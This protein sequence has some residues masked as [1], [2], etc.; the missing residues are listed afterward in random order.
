VLLRYRATGEDPLMLPS[1]KQA[2]EASKMLGSRSVKSKP[3]TLV[4]T[5][6]YSLKKPATE[7]VI[8]LV[9]A[10]IAA[11]G[12]FVQPFDGKCETCGGSVGHGMVLMNDVPTY[13]CGT[14]QQHMI[15]QRR[16]EAEAYAARDVQFVKGFLAA[17]VAAGVMA[18]AVAWFYIWIDKD[19]MLPI[20]AMLLF[21]AFVGLPAGWVFG[22]T[23]GRISFRAQAVPLFLLGT[24]GGFAAFTGYVAMY[25]ARV[26]GLHVGVPLLKEVAASV[27]K[28]HFHGE[29]LWAA[30]GYLIS[31]LACV[32]VV[33]GLEPKFDVK[34]VPLAEAAMAQTVGGK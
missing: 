8:R 22:K 26:Y 16:L 33:K 21:P 27:V 20:K 13:M 17:V 15:D 30:G 9:D 2:F 29:S 14:C 24:I 34:F 3:G 5:W 18:F 11:I 31:G 28:M 1:A 6:N 32:G 7:E 4:L 23:V 10:V 19:G 25:W 12:A